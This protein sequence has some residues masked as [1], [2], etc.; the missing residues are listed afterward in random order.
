MVPTQIDLF[1]EIQYPL[2]NQLLNFVA[3]R[4]A[5]GETE[6]VIGI[7][8]PGGNVFSGLSAYNFLRG[9]GERIRTHNVGHV[10]S[11]AGVIYCAGI[12]RGCTASSRFLIHDIVWGFQS[13]N[14]SETQI[15]ESLEGLRGDRRSVAT[16]LA[17]ALSKTIAEVEQMMKDGLTL[18]AEEAEAL[19]LA[20]SVGD[21][22]YDPKLPIERIHMT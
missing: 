8:S 11:I 2:V 13:A 7:S 10:H 19:G 6:F 5:D 17:S 18:H 4:L 16:V 20:T 12:E 22:I 1:G 9:C 3:G 14:Y 21:V 15:R